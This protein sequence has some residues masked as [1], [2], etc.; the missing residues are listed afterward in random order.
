[1]L[2]T[3]MFRYLGTVLQF[4]VLA[5]IARSIP[6]DEYGLY[7]L[8]LSFVF[9]FYYFLG[10]GASESALAHLVR[11]LASGRNTKVGLYVGTVL[12]LSGMC[13]AVLLLLAGAISIM[14][15]LAPA[16]NV[17]L[18]F[19]L[20]FLSANGLMFNVSQVLLGLRRIWMGSFF[21]Y[22]AINLVLLISTVPTALLLPDTSFVQLSIA[23]ATG[24]VFASM[25]AILTCVGV[26]R[27]SSLEFSKQLGYKLIK[28]GIG[29]TF[30][31]IL[32]VSSF[33]IP[34][35][36]SGLL[37][38]PALAG[39]MGTAGR[40]AIAVSAVI[41]A[42]R[43]FI[44]PLINEALEMNQLDKL[45]RIMSAVAFLTMLP[46]IGVLIINELAGEDIIA[47][48]FGEALGPVAPLL[49]IL[50]ISVI[51]EAIFGPVDE[52]L[53]AAGYQKAVGIIYGTA[54]PLFLIGSILVSQ[55][56]LVWIAW[57]QVLYVT[58]I[59]LAMNLIVKLHFGFFILPS[60]PTMNEL[61]KLK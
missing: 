40:L 59:F 35:M 33:W 18:I 34:T 22:P 32:H 38:S 42:I 37:L 12:G 45:R 24:A 39:I 29:L 26:V 1:M 9:S 30:L 4:I 48:F 54:V 60:L 16:S 15:P 10:A 52:L 57:L 17:S 6:S 49:S 58:G 8:C 36:V 44:R 46:A 25:V 27:G 53:K 41:A 28:E 21:F 47:F 50:L 23:T 13:A 2:T 55:L 7:I 19:T 61:R 3:I 20:V 56:G 43:F 5:V 51:S 31:R 11:D 14:Q